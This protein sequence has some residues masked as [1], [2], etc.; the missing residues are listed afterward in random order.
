MFPEETVPSCDPATYDRKQYLADALRAFGH[1]I[2]KEQRLYWPA[3]TGMK[4]QF[5]WARLG[6]TA[7]GF[8]VNAGIIALVVW[9]VSLR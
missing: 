4:T 9:L 3:Y 6:H 5:T 8:G 2:Y 7:F 1:K